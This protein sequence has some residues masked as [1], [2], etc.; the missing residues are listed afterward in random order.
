MPVP[1]LRREIT[2]NLID[3]SYNIAVRADRKYRRT[4]EAQALFTVAL[5]CFGLAV[6][7]AIN[8]LAD[9]N[10]VPAPWDLRARLIAAVILSSF[11]FSLGYGWVRSDQKV[12]RGWSA[13]N[14][15]GLWLAGGLLPPAALLIPTRIAA[16]PAAVLLVA[17]AWCWFG[18]WDRGNVLR[19]IMAALATVLAAGLAWAI[20]AGSNRWRLGLT[21]ACVAL[22]ELPRLLA[23][24]FRPAP[25][26]A[27][28][29]R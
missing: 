14:L 10:G 4:G 23:A 19:E 8:V 27:A 25:A 1:D 16:I 2:E 11:G 28:P 21:V 18:Q 26:V 22:F 12:T 7:L 9:P 24:T 3:E 17:Q 5:P 20:L 29:P 15:Y 13:P 6:A